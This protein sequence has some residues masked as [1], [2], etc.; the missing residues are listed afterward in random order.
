MVIAGTKSRHWL[1]LY[2]HS[3]AV[4]FPLSLIT[5]E[6]LLAERRRRH[7]ILNFEINHSKCA[8][9]HGVDLHLLLFLLNTS[10]RA[11]PHDIDKNDALCLGLL[12]IRHIRKDNRHRPLLNSQVS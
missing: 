8:M 1:D 7:L 3:G 11:Y 6:I 4:L 12:C 2:D 10:S 9:C 5:Q